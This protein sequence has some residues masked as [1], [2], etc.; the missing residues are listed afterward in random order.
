MNRT[1]NVSPCDRNGLRDCRRCWQSWM[2]G[3]A[4]CW[5][6]ASRRASVHR[7]SRQSPAKVQQ[8]S[9]SDLLV[10]SRASRS[11]IMSDNSPETKKNALITRYADLLNEQSDADELQLIDDLEMVYTSAR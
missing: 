9:K 6:C 11:S 7:R 3:S 5:R 2:S 4:S 10:L 8:P 1:P